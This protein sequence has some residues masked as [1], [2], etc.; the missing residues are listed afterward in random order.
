MIE[1]HDAIVGEKLHKNVL[2]MTS[3]TSEA[4]RNTSLDLVDSRNL[5]KQFYS[6]RPANQESLS[7]WIDKD[8]AQKPKVPHAS[9]LPHQLNWK[10][11]EQA[12][13]FS[14]KNYEELLS[15]QGIGPA[16]VRGLA[17][18]SE[19][20]YGTPPSWKDPVKFS[21]A[22][23]GKDGLPFPVDRK[24]M[25]KA[26]EILKFSIESAAV[27]NEKLRALERLRRFVPRTVA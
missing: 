26:I 14:P 18:V 21:Y 6:I 22:F 27:G 10:A 25:D 12:Y 17:L 8:L 9:F 11:L 1:P 3:R 19:L 2:D 24:A 4:C 16:T 7:K 15:F 23:G 13:N 20:M 5:R